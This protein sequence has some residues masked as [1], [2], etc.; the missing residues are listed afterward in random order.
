MDIERQDEKESKKIEPG[1][2]KDATPEDNHALTKEEFEQALRKV[3]RPL[4]NGR[5]EQE[6]DKQS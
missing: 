1:M 5:L 6:S 3:S 2:S 4:E